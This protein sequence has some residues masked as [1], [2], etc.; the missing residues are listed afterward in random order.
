ML[1]CIMGKSATGKDS[2]YK[3]LLKRDKTLNKV[4]TYTTRPK[5]D[6]EINNVQYNFV[7]EKFLIDNKN[8]I[9]EER[10][11]HTVYGDWHYATLDDGNILPDKKYLII[12]TLESYKDLVKFFG[13]DRVIP[14]YI[15]VDYETRHKRAIER[16]K[17]NDKLKLMEVERRFIADEKDFCEENLNNLNIKKR[18]TNKNLNDCIN[19][20]LQFINKKND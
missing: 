4:I 20:I 15:E 2:I 12:G 5:R 13:S 14:I 8:K 6:E 7:D 19:E 18:F 3:E 11:Y 1:F 17:T 9:I 10:I 16:E